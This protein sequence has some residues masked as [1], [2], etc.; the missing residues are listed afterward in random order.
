MRISIDELEGS[1]EVDVPEL[2]T[3]TTQDECALDGAYW[4]GSGGGLANADACLLIHGA[5]SMAWIALWFGHA[6]I[7]TLGSEGSLE[8]MT[9]GYVDE[10]WAKQHHNLWHD[11]VA[12]DGSASAAAPEGGDAAGAKGSPA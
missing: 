3:V 5:T 1:V 4:Q 9:T 12:K 6:Y 7:G 2:V 11:E 10:N 8:G